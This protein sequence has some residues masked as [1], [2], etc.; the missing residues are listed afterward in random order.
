MP[1]IAE[2]AAQARVLARRSANA[3][4]VV[5]GASFHPFRTVRDG[6]HVVRGLVHPPEDPIPGAPTD[7]R[8]EP[9]QAPASP[10]DAE[11]ATRPTAGAD[12]AVRPPAPP[13]PDA[14]PPED[15]DRPVDARGPAPHI[16]PRIAEEV[17]RDYGDDLPG[18]TNGAG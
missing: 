16:P 15:L 11:T 13:E 5:I 7:A 3:A 9:A 6:A 12:T 4:A 8:E 14:V 2:A 17:E 1:V 18:F 10:R